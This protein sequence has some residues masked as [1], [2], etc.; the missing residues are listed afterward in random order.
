MIF[1]RCFV[2]A[3]PDGGGAEFLGMMQGGSIE[4]QGENMAVDTM[5][6]EFAGVT[7]VPKHGIISGEMFVP[8][9]G[10]QL[11]A[12]KLWLETTKIKFRAQFIGAGLQATY[13]GY[14]DPP[15]LKFGTSDHTMLSFKAKVKMSAFK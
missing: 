5:G 2:F 14:M 9:T 6:E 11:D 15:S 12:F 3:A 8:P 7:T 4:G 13:E 1:D 10:F